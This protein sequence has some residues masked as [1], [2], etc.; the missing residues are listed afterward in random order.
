VRGPLEESERIG[1]RET[2]RLF[3]RALRY[4][5]PFRGRFA[6]K[7]GITLG[8][9]IPPLFLPWP[10]KILIDH[11]IQGR[12]LADA[13][14][15]YPFFVR[16]AVALLSG[17][18]PLGILLWTTG[19]QFVLLL[20]IGAIGTA[21]RENDQVEAYLSGGFDSATNTENEANAGFSFVGGL[22]GLI[23]FHFTLRL[24]QDLNHHYRSR[25]FE[26]IQA[27]PMTAFDDERI[28]DAVYRVMYDTPAITNTCYRLLLTPI[29]APFGLLLSVGVLELV[30]G[31]HPLLV[32]SALAFLPLSI[33]ASVPFAGLVR[34][35]GERSRKAGATT[36][37]T[38]EE[39][40]TNVL[41]V[42]SLGGHGREQKRFGLDSWESFSRFRSYLLVGILAFLVALIPG[43]FIGARA[44]LYVVDLVIRGHISVGDFTLLFTYFAQIGFFAVEIGALWIR[45][46]GSAPGLHRVFFLM[47]LPGE[48]DPAGARPL[49][50][51]TE[52]VQLDAVDFDYPDGTPALRGVSL[53]LPVGKVTA[54]VGPAG[55]GKTT[56]AYLVPRFLEP[57][58]GRVLLDRVDVAQ[59]TRASLREQIAFVFQETVLFD[60]TVEEN[61]RM[62]RP[63][64]SHS[65][66]RRAAQQAGA[67]EFIRRLPQGYATRLGRAGGKLSVGQKQRLA[68]ARALVREAG[69]LILDEPTSAL[70]PETER[71]VVAAL[72]EAS[73]S[74]IV[75]VIAHRLSTVRAADQIVFVEEGRIVERGSHEELMRR[76]GGAYQRFVELE[77]RGAA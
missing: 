2:L 35:R 21:L 50:K 20:A 46:Q 73:R 14:A 25:L 11:V 5:R 39:G 68:I 56:L 28:G 19:A 17:T 15:A 6:T 71:R 74:R 54:L 60:D 13:V 40:V 4:V 33:L 76:T 30:F 67:D 70:D 29:A 23:D 3:A 41:A 16:P 42:Q 72:R 22:I 55:A 57:T 27:L 38:V 64:A 63:Q 32:W 66:I 12:P 9:L 59:A 31:A 37:S 44:Y 45:V 8:S 1:H 7:V 75:L 48:K 65:E 52:S 49:P 10:V 47:D 77:T 24:T 61:I 34:R 53:D 26:R 43:V 18:S 62:G 69:I 58:R 51:V 36:T